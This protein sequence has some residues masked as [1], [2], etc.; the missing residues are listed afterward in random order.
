MS[1]RS[2]V[3][4][5]W[6][7]VALA[8]AGQAASPA[9]DPGE[10]LRRAAAAGDR[11]A[12]ERSLAAGTPVDATNRYGATALSYA[13]DHGHREIVALL[14]D[15]GADPN[16]RDTFYNGAVIGWAFDQPEILELLLDRGAKADGEALIGAVYQGGPEAV[17]AILARKQVDAAGL[18]QALAAAEQV[19]SPEK[20]ALLVAAGAVPLP[21]ANAEVAV[22]VLERYAGAYVGEDGVA[23]KIAVIDGKLHYTNPAGETSPLGAVDERTFRFPDQPITVTFPAGEGPSESFSVI[24]PDGTTRVMRRQEAAP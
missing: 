18:T 16:H 13:A 9:D 10:Q 3:V 6:A 15:R 17:A 11:A 8:A 20:V 5:S 19:E 12:V 24:Y 1:M 23:R 14:L 21:P 4:G 22:A 7:L 2:F